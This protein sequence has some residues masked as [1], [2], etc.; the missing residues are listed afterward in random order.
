MKK[1]SRRGFG[2]R[3]I[4]YQGAI[5]KDHRVL[6]ITHQEH[7]SN[8]IYWV[9]PGGGIEYGESETQCVIREM[10]EETNLV[11]NVDRLLLDEPAPSRGIYKRLKTYLCSIVNGTPAPGSEPEASDYY[12]ITSVQWFDL[13]DPASWHPD[14]RADD[15]TRGQ[16]ERIRDALGYQ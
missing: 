4:R 1:A 3:E 8:R 15:I 2:P 6:L 11:V 9:I 13:R 7:R 12:S 14:M 16:V 5:V 10:K